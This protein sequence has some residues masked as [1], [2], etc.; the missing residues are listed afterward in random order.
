VGEAT[1]VT[2]TA[3][4]GRSIGGD[5]SPVRRSFDRLGRIALH[6][7]AFALFGLG[8]L[9][10]FGVVLPLRLLFARRAESRDLAAQ[11]L[12]H[13]AVRLYLRVCEAIGVFSVE[14]RHTERLTQGP[15]LVVANHP[16]LL[17]V[18]LLLAQMPQADCI[19]K[20]AVWRNPFLRLIVNAAAYI[21]NDTAEGL[22]E[23]CCKSLSA[24]RSVVLFPEGSRSP[25][26]GMREF[27]RGAAHIALASGCCV[28]PVLLYCE[29]PALKKGQPWYAVPNER[30]RFRLEV[31]LPLRDLTEG[32]HGLPRS[33]AARRVNQKL[34]EYF[35]R[36]LPNGCAS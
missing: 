3:R 10:T 7:C 14:T 34:R 2:S 16:T 5:A 25:L 9:L 1:S 35:E 21:P 17:D 20:R 19:A 6:G 28:V 33:L 31:D 26:E 24:G 30:M 29:P 12:V 4:P 18:V 11:R 15:A 13:R 27:Q 8:S 36:R 22:V 32:T 23:R